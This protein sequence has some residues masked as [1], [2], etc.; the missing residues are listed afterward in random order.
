MFWEQLW[1]Q[2]RLPTPAS[3]TILAPR[4]YW[5]MGRSTG[6]SWASLSSPVQRSASCW[7]PSPTRRSA[8]QCSRRSCSTSSE[9][10]IDDQTGRTFSFSSNIKLTIFF[11]FFKVI[12]PNIRTVF[13]TF[14]S[15][16]NSVF[17]GFWPS[18]YFNNSWT[19]TVFCLFRLPLRGAGC[20]PSLWNQLLH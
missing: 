19:A 12:K 4:S 8:K 1:S 7:T 2:I 10:L 3:C 15:P 9:V 20:A 6:R 16:L 14:T 18:F 13:L 5:R 11:P 17:K